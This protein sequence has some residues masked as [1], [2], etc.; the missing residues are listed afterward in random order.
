M[1]N[2]TRSNLQYSY[3]WVTTTGDSKLRGEPDRSLLNR[4]EGYEVL[5][6]IDRLMSAW[7]LSSVADGQ[8]IERLIRIVPSHLHSQEHVKAWINNNWNNY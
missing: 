2:F 7:R 5:Y 1:A 4:S 3:S 6:M 8:K